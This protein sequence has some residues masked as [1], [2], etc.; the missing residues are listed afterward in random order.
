MAVTIQN[1]D[2]MVEY[3]GDNTIDMDGDTFKG[4]LYNST[5]TFTQADTQ[6]SDI[7]ANALAT[8]FGYTNPGQDLTTPTWVEGSGTV[9]FDAADQVWTA[10]GGSIGPARHMV[11]YSDTASAPVD[12]L[13]L[14][15]NFGQDETAGDGTDFR[16][17]FNATGIF[18]I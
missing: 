5:H 10:S 7:V 16:V 8:N 11:I 15:I 18:Q 9:T 1:Y 6:R 4:E 17:N 12:A 14:N 3:F 2:K 13:M